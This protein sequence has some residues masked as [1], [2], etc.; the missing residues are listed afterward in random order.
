LSADAPGC[1]LRG[2]QTGQTSDHR[3]V[4]RE[5][6][7]QRAESLL[8]EAILAGRYAAGAAL[9]AERELAARL[10]VTR[11]TL[12]EALQRLH[13]DGWIAI[14][15]GRETRVKDIWREGGLNV[16]S[17]VVQHGRALP[18]G[19]VR[20]LLDVRTLLAPAY[21]RAAVSRQAAVVAALLRES[22]AL[23]ESA[24]EF[25]RF[26]WDLH[27]ALAT[28]SGNPI[29]A[30]IL[31]GF[32]GFY[33]ELA[34]RYFAAAESRRA[35]RAFYRALGEA[36]RRGAAARAEAVTRAAMVHSARLWARVEKA[37]RRR[38]RARRS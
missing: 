2:M 1:M 12:R 14:R 20:Q 23:P 24:R 10:G 36:A 33:H 8:V 25:A 7:A 16:L 13:R 26:D 30:L 22:E 5:R 11:P 31:N 35:S 18:P 19:F 28:G 6:P 38:A 17:A 15:Q 37:G 9:P 27:H 29:H 4:P 3:R 34:E 21:A 32:A